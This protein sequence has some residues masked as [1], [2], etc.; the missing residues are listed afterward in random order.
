MKIIKHLLFT[1]VL[2]LLFLTP[3]GV[4]AAACV[5]AEFCVGKGPQLCGLQ[6]GC[7]F[8]NPQCITSPACAGRAQASCS[9]PYC[10]WETTG[11]LDNQSST[12]GV[13][14]NTIVSLDNPLCPA[15]S[16]NC[17]S[18]Q[19]LMGKIINSILGVVGSIALIMFIFGGLT[20]MTSGGSADKIKKGRDMIGWSIVGL[21]VIFASYGLVRF[22]ILAIK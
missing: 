22:L 15:G 9:L 14:D 6:T 4:K 2:S 16:P 11:I 21:A 8:Q 10:R 19:L 12:T 13:L 20:W 7:I 3:M 1:L 17:T 18:P 5:D